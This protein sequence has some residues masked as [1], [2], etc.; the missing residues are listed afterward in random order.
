MKSQGAKWEC[1]RK[2]EKKLRSTSL[3]NP[4]FDLTSHHRSQGQDEKE[5]TPIDFV[6]IVTIKCE[7]INDLY[8]EVVRNYRG[9][10]NPL[11]PQLNIQIGL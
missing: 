1:V 4:V 10:L 7:K 5:K 8:N 6:C 9:I 2:D 11:T 3:L